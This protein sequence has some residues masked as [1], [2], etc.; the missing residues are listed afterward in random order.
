M[1]G[2][3]Y[4][5][6]GLSLAQIPEPELGTHRNI[7]LTEKQLVTS[8]VDII[9]IYASKFIWHLQ[10]IQR[11]ESS[12]ERAIRR[13]SEFIKY[14]TRLSQMFS[15]LQNSKC[16]LPNMFS[17][18][19]YLEGNLI[20][21]LVMHLHLTHQN[22]LLESF[23]VQETFWVFFISS[24]SPFY[25]ETGSRL[26]LTINEYSPQRIWFHLRHW[27]TTS[28]QPTLNPVENIFSWTY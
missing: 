25:F 18:N 6:P 24:S 11:K 3:G 8:A 21:M 1:W 14:L 7:F 22:V 15:V 23:D 12:E 27:E 19:V 28:F 26:L 13:L 9:L 16:I 10:N 4:F 20:R 17:V 5:S 2:K